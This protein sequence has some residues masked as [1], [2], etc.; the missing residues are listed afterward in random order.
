MTTVIMS[1]RQ[2]RALSLLVRYYP[3]LGTR[4]PCVAGATD[5]N[6]DDE[7]YLTAREMADLDRR[8]RDVLDPLHPESS[9]VTTNPKEES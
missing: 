1:D 3:S 5:E 9:A 2:L 6:V 4:Y 7:H 8:F